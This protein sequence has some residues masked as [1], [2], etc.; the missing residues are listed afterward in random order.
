MP[1]GTVV[2]PAAVIV[3]VV[4]LSAIRVTS[5]GPA[6]MAS[7]SDSRVEVRLSKPDRAPEPSPA[8]SRRSGRRWRRPGGM[9]LKSAVGLVPS[10]DESTKC[11]EAIIRRSRL[12]VEAP[13]SAAGGPA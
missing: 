3:A 11:A 10:R 9:A 1:N 12:P 4:I 13:R 5:H 7:N 6:K 2:G 8:R